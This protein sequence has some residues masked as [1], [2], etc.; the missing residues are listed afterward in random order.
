GQK[1]EHYAPCQRRT[2]HKPCGKHWGQ[3]PV[4]CTLAAGLFIRKTRVW[5]T[6]SA[7]LSGQFRALPSKVYESPHQ[8]AAGRRR[9]APPKQRLQRGY[10]ILIPYV[11]MAKSYVFNGLMQRRYRMDRRCAGK[12]KAI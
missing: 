6:L 4:H 12:M 5:V 7:A 10:K 8:P 9:K 1:Y 2:A 11:T 3:T